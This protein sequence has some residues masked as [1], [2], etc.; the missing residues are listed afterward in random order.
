MTVVIDR[1]QLADLDALVR[2]ENEVF[3]ASD[4]LLSRRAFRY[5]LTSKNE[6]LVARLT[7]DS[8]QITGYILSLK[9]KYSTRIYS[10][11][12]SSEFQRQGI[13]KTLIIQVI[14]NSVSNAIYK[15]KLEARVSNLRAINLYQSLGFKA[16]SIRKSYY[17]DA[18]DACCMHWQYQREV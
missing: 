8:T 14:D 2:L 9:H 5:H 1:A 13:A 17:E 4:G 15:L 7:K 3:K 10:L 6:L 16:L 11:A 18:E 12:I